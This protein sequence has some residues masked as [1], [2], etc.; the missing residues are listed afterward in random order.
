MKRI[1]NSAPDPSQRVPRLRRTRR[2]IFGT[3]TAGLVL[4]ASAMTHAAQPTDDSELRIGISA[5]ILSFDP[6]SRALSQFV[7]AKSIYDSLLEFDGE[8]QPVP[9]LAE[10]WQINDDRTAI[11]VR[12]RDD[13]EFHSGAP[14]D[15]AAVVANFDRAMSEET[16]SHMFFFTQ[17]VAT[18]EAVDDL[19]VRVTFDAAVPPLLMFDVLQGLSIVDPSSFDSLDSTASGTGPYR[20]V[21]RTP[22]QGF[23]LEAFPEWWGGT[24]ALEGVEFVVFADADAKVAALRAGDI[25]VAEGIPSRSAANLEEN[26][27]AV[28]TGNPGATYYEMRL[29]PNSAVFAE[30]ATRQ[31][32]YHG[33]DRVGIVDTVLGGYS[34]PAV[35]PFFTH[36]ADQQAALVE[37]YGPDPQQVTAG[38]ADVADGFSIMV[39]SSVPETVSIAEVIQATLKAIAGVDVTIER[40]EPAQFT[41]RLT[42]GDYDATVTIGAGG[43]KF[44]TQITFGSAWRL[45]RNALWGDDTPPEYADAIAQVLAART[46]EELAASI[47]NLNAVVLDLAVDATIADRPTLYASRDTV[48]GVLLNVDNMLVL[49]SLTG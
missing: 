26:G 7:I 13:V 6:Y 16:G 5:D 39:S 24:P 17:P 4:G 1:S 49:D 30:P 27:F 41:E 15:A 34:Q 11:E 44:P 46:P 25:D 43:Q 22:G 29:N 31:A 8:L 47:D 40:V 21:S 48:D 38:F 3:A 20:V 37:E 35:T 23:E 42:A 36:A 9:R 19:T 2:A 12:L 32:V 45:T 33:I 10:S 14:L 28:L 18:A